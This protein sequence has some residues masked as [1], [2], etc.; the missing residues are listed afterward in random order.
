[1]SQFLLP[2]EIVVASPMDLTQQLISG[3]LNAAVAPFR[4]QV[5]E[6]EYVELC[7]EEHRLYCALGHPLFS[8]LDSEICLETI[9]RYQLCQRSYDMLVSPELGS[10]EPM[11]VVANMEA[12]A[13]LIETGQFLRP[14][15]T[16][17]ARR[18]VAEGN[19]REI[20]NTQIRWNSTFYLA[21]RRVHVLRHAVELFAQDLQNACL[22]ETK[23]RE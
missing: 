4:N 17:F 11:A 2:L 8:E 1:M 19:F 6:L 14:L 18:R 15:P 22:D 12:M 9:G 20:R 13:M 21:T 3:E 16:H 10:P 7:R 5:P 23:A